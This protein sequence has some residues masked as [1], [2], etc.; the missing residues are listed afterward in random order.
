MNLLLLLHCFLFII[1]LSEYLICMKYINNVYN[2][3]NEQIKS[4][5]SRRE[6]LDFI[7]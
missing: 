5:F 6:K 3:K 1:T 4:S 7:S 2:Y